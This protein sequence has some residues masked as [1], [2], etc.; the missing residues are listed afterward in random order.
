ML[1]DKDRPDARSA[2]SEPVPVSQ[3]LAEAESQLALLVARCDALDL[4]DIDLAVSPPKRD[5]GLALPIV[6][7]AAQIPASESISA[8]WV[9][10]LGM[11]EKASLDDNGS[12]VNGS[13]ACEPLLGSACR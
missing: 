11:P 4:R 1:G 2:L 6:G 8:S 13:R 5:R 7:S 3:Y 10:S 9:L 12:T